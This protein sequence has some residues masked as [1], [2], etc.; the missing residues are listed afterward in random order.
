[1]MGSRVQRFEALHDDDDGDVES[2]AIASTAPKG[3]TTA[4]APASASVAVASSNKDYAASDFIRIY[5]R[6]FNLLGDEVSLGY[7]LAVANIFLSVAL[8]AEPL[9]FGRVINALTLLG[10][11]S[12]TSTTS[13][14]TRLWQELLPLLL[15]WSA[16]SA[17]GAC[18]SIFI[19]LYA[20][21]LSHRRRHVVYAEGS[22][23]LESRRPLASRRANPPVIALRRFT[24]P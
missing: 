3:T 20:D 21:Q 13:T 8:L 4:S 22:S 6:A 12:T 2:P 11:D 7:K 1:M 15:A 9:L 19:G 10:N 17:F 14:T 18:S 24:P 23:R 5:L 16:F